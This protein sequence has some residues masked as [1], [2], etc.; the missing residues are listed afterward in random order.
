M[1]L[2]KTLESPLDCKEIQPVHPKGD[3]SWVFIGR[4]DLKL[5]LQYFGH[6]MRRVDSLEKTH[7]E[8][9]WWQEEKGTTEDEMAGWHHGL[10]EHEFEYTL[11]VGDGQG[12]LAYCD[13]WGRRVGHD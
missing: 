5:K 3:Q 6:L 12:G 11:G 10:D 1:V 4:T 9:D 13:S 8:R 2:E 7:A